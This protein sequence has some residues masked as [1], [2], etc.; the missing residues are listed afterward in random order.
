M[1]NLNL[2]SILLKEQF[3]IADVTALGKASNAFAK[4]LIKNKI[5]D[6][7]HKDMTAADTTINQY[8]EDIAEV[9]R[10]EVIKW[11]DMANRRGGR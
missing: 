2:K 7:H 10:N 8:S 5:I 9:V 11:M 4:M 1:S 6:S 3:H